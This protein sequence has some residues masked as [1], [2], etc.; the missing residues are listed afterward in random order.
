M[1]LSQS[2][3]LMT[4]AMTLCTVIPCY[5]QTADVIATR[6][7]IETGEVPI[8][9]TPQSASGSR[10]HAYPLA[11]YIPGTGFIAGGYLGYESLL[12]DS[13]K[14][15]LYG[16]TSTGATRAFV[17][18][19][20]EK[21]LMG[22]ALELRLWGGYTNIEKSIYERGNDASS[23]TKTKYMPGQLAYG[24]SLKHPFS[25]QFAATVKFESRNWNPDFGTDEIFGISA[26]QQTGVSRSIELELER[27]SRDD[28]TDPHR[29]GWDR[30]SLETGSPVL[31]SEF[32]YN[33]LAVRLARYRPLTASQ[34]LALRAEFYS[35]L[36]GEA[37]PFDL[38]SLGGATRMRGLTGA[39]YRADNAALF[40]AEW[41][42]RVSKPLMF[43]VFGEAG[44]V[45]E[46]NESFD[47]NDMHLTAGI[48]ARYRISDSVLLR[49]DVGYGIDGFKPIGSLGHAF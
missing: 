49:F 23:D 45:W 42:I 4:G 19:Y 8:P 17:L 34:T 48:G 41:R 21:E 15:E 29:G 12:S 7:N 24:I 5:A 9:A 22:K 40:G 18:T 27:D 44:K 38:P 26:A 36:S 37:A 25:R 33:Q 20:T 46:R 43:A 1:Q 2:L 30:V 13:D 10:L 14:L 47:L 32:T 11:L 16:G 3:K 6:Q 31:G 39:R 28:D 35:V